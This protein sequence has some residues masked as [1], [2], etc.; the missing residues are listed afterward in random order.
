MF[1]LTQHLHNEQDATQGQ[2]LSKIKQVSIQ[3]FPSPK[4]VGSFGICLYILYYS[5][6]ICYI[7]FIQG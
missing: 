2:F 4:L 6:Y 1:V 7:L 3:S 5:W